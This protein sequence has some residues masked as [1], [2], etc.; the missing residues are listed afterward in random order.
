M[1]GWLLARGVYIHFAHPH[2]S[3]AQ[4]G[5]GRG[6]GA[7]QD[8]GFG[9]NN[10]ADKTLYLYDDIKEPHA[11]AAG[12]INPYLVDAVDVVLPRRSKP[13]CDACNAQRQQT[14]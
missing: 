3:V 8:A 4:R 9:L 6:G 7:G 5:Q 13:M 14:D 2:L 12:N 1:P 10:L 11:V